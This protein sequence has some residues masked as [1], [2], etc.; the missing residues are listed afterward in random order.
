MMMIRTDRLPDAITGGQKRRFAVRS[1]LVTVSGK[2]IRNIVIFDNHF[3]SLRLLLNSDLTPRRRNE[4]FYAV[5]TIV[6]VLAA[7]VVMFWSLL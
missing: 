4:V 7:G 1:Q 5:L 6:L 2:K 3:D